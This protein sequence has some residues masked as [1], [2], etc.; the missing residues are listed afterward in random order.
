[1]LK[2]LKNI[3]PKDVSTLPTAGPTPGNAKFVSLFTDAF[4]AG[5]GFN[6]NVIN[7]RDP[8]TFA[9]S[10]DIINSPKRCMQYLREL[11][12]HISPL[13]LML[14][15]ALLFLQ[16]K[17]RLAQTNGMSYAFLPSTSFTGTNPLP[18]ELPKDVREYLENT[19]VTHVDDYK[20]EWKIKA[21]ELDGITV[22][23]P[24]PIGP[25]L[26]EYYG[27]SAFDNDGNYIGPKDAA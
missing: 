19:G 16:T 13:F 26:V 6:E 17:A 27:E 22:A 23:F 5:G 8:V 14:Y 1:L 3:N 9:W 7:T 18:H 4:Q 2:E 24:F 10:I 21:G 25:E 20:T 12:G 15:Q 11:F